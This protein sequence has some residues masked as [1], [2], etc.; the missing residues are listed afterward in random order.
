MH[1]M[2]KREKGKKIR[3]KNFFKNSESCREKHIAQFN[4][5]VIRV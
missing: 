5:M 4:K 3:E 1:N 2:H